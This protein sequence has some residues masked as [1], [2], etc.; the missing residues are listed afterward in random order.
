MAGFINNIKNSIMFAQA[1]HL[2]K[3]ENFSKYL[4][5]V[6][7]GKFDIKNEKIKQRFKDC[8]DNELKQPYTELH[9][10]TFQDKLFL[11][12]IYPEYMNFD[13]DPLQLCYISGWNLRNNQEM[14]L[15]K[16]FIADNN[17]YVKFRDSLSYLRYGHY[18]LND[19]EEKNLLSFM[20]YL[21]E[22]GYNPFPETFFE[23]YSFF[24]EEMQKKLIDNNLITTELADRLWMHS[25]FEEE[26]FK[27]LD[28]I[29]DISNS[30]K[31]WNNLPNNQNFEISYIE[32]F[33]KNYTQNKN[34]FTP[35]GIPSESFFKNLTR[36]NFNRFENNQTKEFLDLMIQ[37]KNKVVIRTIFED[38]YWDD[39][40]SLDYHSMKDIFSEVDIYAL[41]EYRKMDFYDIK[42]KFMSLY[43]TSENIKNNDDV[44]NLYREIIKYIFKEGNWYII[45]DLNYQNMKDIFSEADIYALDK[46]KNSNDYYD[47]NIKD[48][49]KEQFKNVY[50]INENIKNKND[51]DNLYARIAF[52]EKEWDSVISLDYRN[53]ND[54]FSNVDIYALDK[55]NNTDIYS[56]KSRFKSIYVK[57]ENIKNRDDVDNLYKEILKN[58]FKE[59]SWDYSIMPLDYHNM[60]DIFSEADIYALDK[61]KNSNFI[62]IKEQ[63]KN[64][65]VISENAK[66]RESIDKLYNIGIKLTFKMGIWNEVSYLDYRNMKDI[67]SEADIYTLD[68]YKSFCNENIKSH[69]IKYYFAEKDIKNI[70]DVDKIYKETIQLAF[71]MG[72]W[73]EVIRSDYHNMKNIFSEADIYA[74]DK[75]KSFNI[76]NTESHFIKYYFAEKDIKNIIDVDKIYKETIQ[77]AFK[78]GIWDE[79]I[80]S[81]YHNMKDIFSEADIYALDKYKNSK[82]SYE[83]DIRKQFISLY[84]INENIKNKNDVD[85][86]YKEIIK[87]IFKEGDWD[88]IIFLDYHDMTDILSKT[89]VYALDKYKNW[90]DWHERNISEHFKNLYITSKNI[91]NIVDV[92][93]I[94]K[95]ILKIAFKKGTWN[96]VI[97]SDYHSMND[98]FSEAD[99]Y[100]LDKYK[101]I[102]DDSIKSYFIKFYFDCENVNNIID[103]DILYKETIKIAFKEEKWNT[104]ILSDYHNMNDIFTNVDIYALDKYKTLDRND[105]KNIFN[106]YY[107]ENKISIDKINLLCDLIEHLNSSN[108][109]EL[110]NFQGVIFDELL[111]TDEPIKNFE[112]IEKIFVKN[113]IPVFAKIFKCFQILYPNLSKSFEFENQKIS[114]ELAKLDFNGTNLEK[115]S[116]SFSPDDMRFQV[117]FNDLFRISLGSNNHSLKEYLKNIENGNT[118]YIS[119]LSGNMTYN[120]LSYLQKETLDIFIAHLE[121]LIDNSKYKLNENYDKLSS[122][123][124]I[125]IISQNFKTTS[126]YDLPDRIVRHFLYFAGINSFEELKNKINNVVISKDKINKERGKRLENTMLTLETGDFIRAVGW[127]SN[128]INSLNMG[129][130]CNEY[131]GSIKGTSSSDNTPLDI[132]FSKIIWKG[133]NKTSIKSTPTSISYGNH[134]IIIK[135]D[136]KKMIISRDSTGEKDV[137][138]DPDK[139]EMFKTLADNHYGVRT[140]ISSTDIDYI[141]IDGDNDISRLKFEIA[142]NGFYIPVVNIE[143]NLLY[144][145]S[146]YNSLKE[147]MSGLSYYDT[148][149]YRLSTEHLYFP[150]IDKIIADM[151]EDRERQI[152]KRS[153]LQ[154]TIKN[155]LSSSNLGID[156]INMK[157]TP[158]LSDNN[159]DLIEIGSTSR[160]TNVPNDS[161]YDFI[162]KVGKQQAIQNSNAILN[163]FSECFNP[164][165]NN[166]HTNRFRGKNIDI[167]G[168][169]AP[170]DIDISIDQKKN[171]E[172]YFSDTSLQDRLNNIKKQYPKDYEAVLANIVYAK[173]LLK[174]EDCYKPY[175]SD[176][177]QSGLGGIGVENWVL[178]NGGS[179]YSAAKSFYDASADKTFDEFK[180]VYKVWDFGQNHE[181][182]EKNGTL[183]PFD[184]YVSDNMAENGYQKMRD[185]CK[186]YLEFVKNETFEITQDEQ[187]ENDVSM[188]R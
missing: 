116:K 52:N 9:I 8:I 51:V 86:L 80:R 19:V 60:K 157:P 53:M 135:P 144:T 186:K 174:K 127:E 58:I 106:H 1:D 90:D 83:T 180:R 109:V 49:I 107:I 85:K 148:E 3:T 143:G 48:R 25:N 187:L 47:S 78:M 140:G 66:S 44:D 18:R 61:Y 176:S 131:L 153:I 120:E 20:K 56:I 183:S 138:Y 101:N 167:E 30:Y 169:N 92:D 11:A 73:D 71:K 6:K 14:E 132:D 184:E 26:T 84:I 117:I 40:I 147:K 75:Y 159:V 97:C 16:K 175:K 164:K 156:K 96:A 68:K 57:S 102:V 155:I 76:E 119:L 122:L 69:F 33:K 34:N 55:Y 98:I 87:N 100:A 43:V 67:F 126:K 179:L 4:S 171:S 162:L 137:S 165:E 151:H 105:V 158:D 24:T 160:S 74:L 32:W 134:Y 125:K 65:Y 5:N 7:S 54:V 133:D 50:I 136:N 22:H 72:I 13:T 36:N 149:N 103:V 185:V 181:P 110:V 17:L 154:S 82:A 114:P 108:S 104:V 145:V 130:V 29:K 121:V 81:D 139:F 93:K 123:D 88:I 63:F 38:E 112:A 62:N 2:V 41:D 27:I 118:L 168:F 141:M 163:K 113:N 39:V 70:I 21:K 177:S 15:I 23:E 42:N 178:Q 95:E 12:N 91:K 129:N 173:E 59:G 188:K 45:M 128:L 161:D 89:D 28:S 115:L 150:G 182:R 37:N 146:E 64:L 170:V 79:V 94:Y 124:K 77:L 31:F 99:I 35:L 142:K 152:A 166:S 111:K 46:Y 10:L 172:I